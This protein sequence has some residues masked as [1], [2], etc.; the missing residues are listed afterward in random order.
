MQ[1]F[2]S[3]L[4]FFPPRLTKYVHLGETINKKA[5]KLAITQALRM[6]RREESAVK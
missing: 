3:A 2:F 1:L 4:S 5:L 6:S